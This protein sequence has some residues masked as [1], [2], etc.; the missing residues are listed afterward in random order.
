MEP[1]ALQKKLGSRILFDDEL[2]N[3]Y[4]SLTH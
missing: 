4:F 2:R 1:L 3:S